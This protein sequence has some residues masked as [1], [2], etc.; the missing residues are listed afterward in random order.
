VVNRTLRALVMATGFHSALLLMY[1]VARIT[2]TSAWA[3]LDDPF[4]FEI[5]QLTFLAV[6][7]LSLALCAAC[8]V[9]YL[10]LWRSQS[11]GRSTSGPGGPMP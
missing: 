10:V 2:L 1:V 9:I 5:P 4:F 7:V 8:V 11:D 3:G 6:G